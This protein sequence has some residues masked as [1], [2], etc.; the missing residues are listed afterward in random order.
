MCEGLRVNKKPCRAILTKITFV[1]K[2]GTVVGA[3]L[4]ARDPLE[5]KGKGIRGVGGVADILSIL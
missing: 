5:V 3:N 2:K 1:M 4:C